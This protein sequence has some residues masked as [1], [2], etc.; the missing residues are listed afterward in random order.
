MASL[1]ETQEKEDYSKDG[2]TDGIGFGLQASTNTRI[3]LVR[4]TALVFINFIH[5]Y[6][7]RL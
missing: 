1:Y 2:Y 7:F 4:N 5:G 3:T 6:M